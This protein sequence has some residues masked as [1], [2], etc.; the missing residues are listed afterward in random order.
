MQKA[1]AIDV[2]LEPKV[3]AA[4]VAGLAMLAIFVTAISFVRKRQYELFVTLHQVL[5]AVILAMGMSV[6]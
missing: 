6:R 1:G 3:Y 2:V 4:M 5:V